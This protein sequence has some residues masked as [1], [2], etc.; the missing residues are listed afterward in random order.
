MKLKEKPIKKK[1]IATRVLLPNVLGGSQLIKCVAIRIASPQNPLENLSGIIRLELFQ[2]DD[3][4]FFQQ[5]HIV[6]GCQYNKTG[7]QSLLF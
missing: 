5:P 7:G 1:K 6:M 3:G 2:G 4:F